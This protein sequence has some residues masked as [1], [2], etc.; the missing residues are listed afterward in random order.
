MRGRGGWCHQLNGLFHWLL[1]ELGFDASIVNCNGF[2]KDEGEWGRD[3][4]HMGIVVRGLPGEDED[5]RF[6]V[7]VGWG[8]AVQPFDPIPMVED[9]VVNQACGSYFL[10][11]SGD[12]WI[13]KR[14]PGGAN[15]DDISKWNAVHRFTEKPHDLAD[16]QETAGVYARGED[17]V[18]LSTV[19]LAVR[20]TDGG[21]GG[22]FFAGDSYRRYENLAGEKATKDKVEGLTNLAAA[23][24]LNEEFGLDVYDTL[25]EAYLKRI[26]LSSEEVKAKDLAALTALQNA[27]QTAVPFENMDVVMLGKQ[28]ILKTYACQMFRESNL[29]ST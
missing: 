5:R 13:L 17:A 26:G 29:T 22:K 11:R 19:V 12:H 9:A 21:S 20:K 18:F 14:K 16:F 1:V 10:A 8:E 27:H 23:D 4:D 28:P 25:V 7:D 24:V 2:R 3:Y 6:F 15:D